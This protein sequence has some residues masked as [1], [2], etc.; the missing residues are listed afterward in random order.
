MGGSNAQKHVVEE[1]KNAPGMLLNRP[2]WETNI[3]LIAIVKLVNATLDLVQVSKDC[4]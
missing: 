4:K 1:H 2:F 3:A